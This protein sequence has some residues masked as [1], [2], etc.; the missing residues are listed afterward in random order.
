MEWQRACCLRKRVGKDIDDVEQNGN[1]MADNGEEYKFWLDDV[2]GKSKYKRC[3]MLGQ[4]IV[5]LFN[6]KIRAGV[7]ENP[8]MGVS[9]DP[10]VMT[11]VAIALRCLHNNCNC[12]FLQSFKQYKEKGLKL[13][14]D[15]LLVYGNN[16]LLPDIDQQSFERQE[17][18]SP[19]QREA[20]ALAS[21]RMSL[22]EVVEVLRSAVDI[23]MAGSAKK[24]LLH[25]SK[26]LN[27]LENEFKILNNN[28][29]PTYEY[30]D[31]SPGTKDSR[32]EAMRRPQ[33]LL[34]A[35]SCGHNMQLTANEFYGL[36]TLLSD[37]GRVGY[38]IDF[39]LTVTNKLDFLEEEKNEDK[40]LAI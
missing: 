1:D 39:W 37:E 9:M 35:L 17:F 3:K 4:Q 31:L 5:S 34:L 29:N 11:N 12:K 25:I 7:Y 6:K 26:C 19:N 24:E 21:R 8:M 28:C 30:V 33:G 13:W 2:S 32:K 36:N 16:S 18:L 22:H 20:I 10:E 23:N 38:R 14:A 15:N 40:V 27:A